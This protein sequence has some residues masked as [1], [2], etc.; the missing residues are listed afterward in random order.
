MKKSVKIFQSLLTSADNAAKPSIR[1]ND[2][3][4]PFEEK[5]KQLQE[6]NNAYNLFSAFTADIIKE[7]TLFTR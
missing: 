4:I 3:I 2:S 1:K 5:E 6:N 7:N